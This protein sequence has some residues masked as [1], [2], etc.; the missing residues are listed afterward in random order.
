MKNLFAFLLVLFTVFLLAG[1]ANAQIAVTVDNPTNTSPALSASYTSLADA[2]TALNSVTAMTGPVT[3]S[4]AANGAETAP[5][6][7]Y[8][9]GS[10][11]LNAVTSAVNTITFVKF[12]V[13]VNPL[14][15][16]FTPGTTTSTD[17]IWKIQGTDYVTIN[18]IDLQE[19]AANLTAT[20]QME[21]GY[22]L[23]K[24]NAAEPFD[25]CQYVT[26][27]NCGV[28]LNKANTVSVGIYAGNHIATATT[29]LTITATTDALNNC[30]FYNN[31][32]SNVYVGIRL[33]GYST[34]SLYDQ[35][36]E[37]G[38][39]PGSGNSITNYGGAGSTAYGIYTIYQNGLLENYN[40]INGGTGTTTTLYGI[41]N[42]TG[43]SSNVTITGNTVTIY[44]GAT[45]SSIYAISN[46]MGSTAASNTVTIANNTVQNC[47]YTTATSGALYGIV[48]SASAAT[49]NINNNVVTGNT[50]PGTGAFTGID[51]GTATNLNMY[52]NDVY[53][54][55]K[56]GASGTMYC[57]RGSTAIVAFYGND[58][59]NNSYTA[60]SGT[61]SCILYGYYNFG[62]PTVENIYGNNI[63][64]LSV[65]GTNTASGSL[66]NGIHTN[67]TSTATK[68]IY[69]NIIHDFSAISGTINGI[70]QSLGTSVKIY[71]NEIFNL[72]NTGSTGVV[73]GMTIASGTVYAY[74]NYIKQ[75]YTPSASVTDAIRGINITSS[76]ALSTVG[77]YYNTIYLNASSTGLNF[78]TTG[79][80]HTYSTTAT[81]ASL[82]MRN[83][84]V[85]NSST[86]AGTGMVAAFRRSSAT[87]LN[88]FGTT[89][90]NND[91]YA[92]TPGASNLIFSDGTN[93]DQTIGAY[94]TRVAPR[95]AASFTELPPFVNIASTPYD[96]HIQTTI[97]T[98]LEKGGTP[99]TTP[100]AI[101]DDYD[102]NI[103]NATLPDVGADEGD[104]TP[105]D[106]TPPT[107]AY[108]PLGNTGGTGNRVLTAAITDGTGVPTAGPGLPVLYWKIDAGA[109]TG[110]TGVYVSGNDYTFMFGSGVSAGNVVSYYIVAQDLVSTP[111]VGAYPSGGASG[112]TANPPAASTPPTTPSSYIIVA[113]PLSGDYTV[114]TTMFN[115]VTGKNITFEKVVTKVIIDEP[116]Y[117]EPTKENNGESKIISYKKTEVDEISWIPM[118]NGRKYAGELYVKKS[119]NPNLNY[120]AGTEGIYTTITAAIAD[121][122]LRGVSGP[123]RFLLTDASYTTGETYPL[124][125]DITSGDV[126]TAVNTVTIKPN[127]GVVAGIS[128]ASTSSIFK[129]NGADYIIIDGSNT[130]DGTTK[131]LTIENTSTTGSVSAIWFASKGVGAGAAYNTIKNCNVKTGLNSLTTSFA[132]YLGGAT[133]GT[134]GSDND[135]NT[136][137]NNYIYKAY[138][139]I[140]VFGTTGSTSDNINII[141][142]TIGAPLGTA[143]DYIYKY[144]IY[145]THATGCTIS[146]NTVQN[147]TNTTGTLY[148][149]YFTT[150]FLSSTVSKN[151]ITNIFY[152]GTGGYGAWGIYT[153]TGS[154]TSNLTFANNMISDIKGDCYTSF[155]ASSPVGMYFDGTTGGLNIYYN[156]VNMS[157]TFAGYNAATKT[158]AIL[159]NTATITNVD[160]RDNIF[161]NTMDNSTVTTDKNYAIYSTAPAGSFT[162]INNNDYYVSGPQGVFGFLNIADVADLAAWK[163]ASGQDANSVSGDPKFTSNTDLHIQVDQISPVSNAGTPIAG[164]T[165]DFDGNTRNVTTPDI[166]ADE[167]TYVPPSVTDPTSFAAVKFHS[168]QIDLSWV[169]NDNSDPIIIATNGTGTFGVP[170]NREYIVGDKLP[171]AANSEIIYVG[172]GTNF[173]H[174]GLTANTTYYY[175]AFSYDGS[176][177]YSPGAT[178]NAATS[179][180]AVPVLLTATSISGTQIDLSWTKNAASN[181]VMVAWNTT[182]TFGT[183]VN[184]TNYA[185]G[186]PIT[187]G[188]TV[189]YNGSGT[190]ANHTSLT[191]GTTYY[192]KAWSVD[193]VYYYSSTGLTANAATTFSIPYTQDFNAGTSLP[194][195]WTGLMTVMATHGTAS[196]NGLTKNL[197]SSTPTTNGVSP[198]MGPVTAITT[199]SFDYRI[200]N[201]SGY[202]ATGTALGASDNVIIQVSS[203]GGSS[204]SDLYTI[205]QSTHVTSSSFASKSFSLASYAGQNVMVK[206]LGTWGTGDYYIDFDNFS[207]I[208]LAVFDPVSFTSTPVGE[209][210]I[211]LAFTPNGNNNNVLI[212][213][214]NTGTFTP[215]SGAPPAIGDPFAGGTLLSN[216]TTSPVNHTG[217][218]AGTVY[219]YKAFSYDGSDYS[220]GL[221]SN[222]TTFCNVTAPFTQ[223]FESVTFPPTCWLLSQ[224]NPW[225]RSTSAS[226]YGT[227]TASAF[228]N[229]YNISSGTIDMTTGD[230]D[231]S[232]F[233]APILKF[234]HAYA[235][236]STENDQL[237]IKYSTNHGTNWTSL[238]IYNGGVSGPLNTGGVTTGSFVPTAAQWATKKITLPTGTNKIQFH[239]ISAY[240]NNLYVDNIQVRNQPVNDAMSVSITLPYNN[241]VGSSVTPTAVVANNGS[242]AATFNVLMTIGSYSSTKT[243]T[244]LAQD[245]S[246]TVTFDNWTATPEGTYTATVTTQL[247]GDEDPT[248]DTKTETAIG[249]F[250]PGDIPTAGGTFPTTT[251]MGSGAS[252][253]DGSN[254]GW[255]FSIGGNTASTFGTECYKYN[256]NTNVWSTIASLPVKRVVLATAVVGNYLYAIAGSDGTS[257]ANTTY[258][259]DIVGDVWTTVATLP[260]AIGWGKAVAYNN[261]IYFA[262][263]IDATNA[264]LSSVYVYNPVTDVWSAATSMPG[265]KFGGAFSIAGNKLVYV[266]GANNVGISNTVYI[267]AI[268]G[269]NPLTIA[270][271]TAVNKFPGLTN[272]EIYSGKGNLSE[273]KILD[274]KVKITDKNKTDKNS[275]GNKVDNSVGKN[276][277]STDKTKIETDNTIKNGNP[278]KF[279]PDATAYPP[280]AM[281]RFDGAQWGSDQIIVTG[282]SP[283]S[284]WVPANP[285]PTYTYNPTTDTW[286]LMPYLGT[287]VLGASIGT[288]ETATGLKLIVASGLAPTLAMAPSNGTQVYT[289]SFPVLNLTALIQG[290]YNG[291]TMVSDNITVELHNSTTPY[292]LVESKI[293]SLSTTGLSAPVFT[294]AKNATPYYIVVKYPNALETWSATPQ[295]F[296]GSALTYDFTT[297][298]TQ[299][300]GSVLALVG[301]KWCIV[302]GDVNQDGFLNTTDYEE[303]NNYVLSG[304]PGGLGVVTDLN[305]DGFVNT[306]DYELWNNNVLAGYS[307]VVPSMDNAQR[308]NIKRTVEKNQQKMQQIK[309]KIKIRETENKN[310]QKKEVN[311]QNNN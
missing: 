98:Q 124:T 70:S 174:S 122:N 75:L 106:L 91:F 311:K 219:Y 284:A 249:V 144:G 225:T 45:S 161:I 192:Y 231:I 83:N 88:N 212:A 108:T 299:A 10:A 264:L 17:G 158:T 72:T 159:F 79:I 138:Y 213:W 131:D 180:P 170:E 222:A 104:F 277:K 109:Y 228:V 105:L 210:Q 99:V 209:T 136:I 40:T 58:I 84:V 80:Y 216:G 15:T 198:N 274:T 142:N 62:S 54:N 259:Y 164:I 237:E 26:I 96:L 278:G 134:A 4:L 240:G 14:I 295:Q 189:L 245:A 140:D 29:S 281:Y 253:K 127:T 150:G 55:Q 185:G 190:S 244:G 286:T 223:D 147:I 276:I 152:T 301:T 193:G 303:W 203:N 186:D 51:G 149:M 66:I 23:V 188:G 53:G 266:G 181:N 227:G 125:I 94:K 143:T 102:G 118:D 252:Y 65:A 232:A 280:G 133:I 27:Q 291:T 39:T 73:Y 64:N 44:G 110:V 197:W 81:T 111:N 93:F 82:D 38:N 135:N 251:Y 156:S 201:Y 52:D 293:V 298:Q 172:N 89:S 166:G 19:N 8:L 224:T 132:V 262:G 145:G 2:I 139:G 153:N 179:P 287:P 47:T 283:S 126:P 275:D 256:A 297:A 254:V 95:D 90:N 30:K 49:V 168:T 208:N 100:I 215:P 282:G 157:G 206:I 48:N 63:Y 1:S 202:P 24:M 16:A 285:C 289:K 60:T 141:G 270:W 37:I 268:D 20:E 273:T 260:V 119:E 235:T 236:Y 31:T 175:K 207:M 218:T 217:L 21:W 194:S 239:A 229:F 71:N 205:N 204:Y 211:N 33:A 13:G 173:N 148:G 78:G 103:R 183:P 137:Q 272:G 76:T 246:T 160:L 248:N 114:G 243:V 130:V 120:P 255:V 68:L 310:V 196:S 221:T 41:Y 59:Y 261:L 267:G 5:A 265:E 250:D 234:D 50:L 115:K 7:G 187:G 263:G 9:L 107:I 306:T 87:N 121:L 12:G 22:A 46:A 169:L 6:G 241:A 171:D 151:N 269:G 220:S 302:S 195:G 97:P 67:T 86:P 18:G 178:A 214:N 85:V 242:A 11:S 128:G 154:A 309:D 304:G 35:N 290:F 279:S 257:Y 199:L 176:Y 155:S 25:G 56:T 288:V 129:L 163:T 101:T 146:Q 308:E 296:T 123:V 32:I 43:T 238:I 112:F 226:G 69:G 117:S 36:N 305:A 233:P 42:S 77:I 74:N 184:T 191:P 292:A 230:F 3:F 247:T 258:R 307:K 200:V 182:N 61:S 162:N 113:A 300:F 34:S 28:T 116:V 271:T 177:Q 167:Y 92:G 57:M 294:V 165:T